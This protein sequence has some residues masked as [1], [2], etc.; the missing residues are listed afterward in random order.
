[1]HDP[2]R[3]VDTL[4]TQQMVEGAQPLDPKYTPEHVQLQSNRWVT[5][6]E[7]QAEPPLHTQ[8]EKI[9]K[10]VVRI[11]GIDVARAICL[12]GMVIA[13]FTSQLKSS[14]LLGVVLGTVNGRAALTFVFVAG[15]GVTLLDR[16]KR[17]RGAGITLLWRAAI[18]I[19]MGI[20]LQM[21]SPGPILILQFYALYYL[22]GWLGARL[23]SW[24]LAIVIPIWTGGGCWFWWQFVHNLNISGAP[25]APLVQLDILVLSGQYPVITWGPMVLLGVL[26]GRVD[27]QN[28]HV[29]WALAVGGGATVGLV[30]GFLHVLQSSA[31]SLGVVMPRW[32]VLEPHSNSITYL[33][34]GYASAVLVVA[35]CVLITPHLGGVGRALAIV[36]RQALTLYV[37]HMFWFV[38]L[39]RGLDMAYARIY[40]SPSFALALEGQL[41][42]LFR[43]L[44]YVAAFVCY[45]LLMAQALIW[46]HFLGMGP[47]E[48]LLRRPTV[49]GT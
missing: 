46:N 34:D 24:L 15:I 36:G 22:V 12:L 43:G 39:N 10:S 27:W 9:T 7:M 26:I 44:A 14:D 11:T 8:G 47:L 28:P 30:H 23:P 48:R 35:L 21:I 6:G 32:L 37:V 2:S 16:A 31:A 42:T 20:G 25:F 13:H 41:N 40:F 19:P 3:P 38:V 49:L 1:M 45:T 5:P 17:P 29:C 33:L 4:N 18:L